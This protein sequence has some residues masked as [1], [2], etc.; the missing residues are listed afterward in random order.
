[1]RQLLCM[2]CL[3]VVLTEVCGQGFE[4]GTFPMEGCI[5]GWS[6]FGKYCYKFFNRRTNWLQAQIECNKYTAKNGTTPKGY[7]MTSK[8]MQHNRFQHNWLRYTG[9]GLNKVWLGLSEKTNNNYFWADGTPLLPNHWNKW[10]VDQPQLNAHIQAVHT[11]DNTADM[12]WVTSFYKTDM[13]FICQYQ[14]KA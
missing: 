3:A 8:D 7:L 5:P 1:M 12:T 11:F 4:P 14:Y 10:K 9:G 2:A 6:N 13:T